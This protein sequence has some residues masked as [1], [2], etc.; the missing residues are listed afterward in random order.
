MTQ[1]PPAGF[2]G[3]TFGVRRT[4]D[5]LGFLALSTWTSIEA[6]SNATAGRP[7]QTLPSQPPGDNLEG[8]A[9]DLFEVPEGPPLPHGVDRGGAL[10]IVWARVAPHAE[11][12][13]HDMIRAV[14]PEVGA[15][16]VA[17]IQ[18]GRR[19]IGDHTELLVVASWR[20][21]LALHEF[22]Q[23][24]TRGTLDPAFLEL[25]TEWRFET[26]DCLPPGAMSVPA[27]G[28]AVLLADDGARYVD[29]SPGVETLLGVPA[30]LVLRQTL[31]DL[32]PP[33]DRAANPARWAQF[34][35]AGE[36]SGTFDILR[37]DG[38]LQ[39]VQFRALA[40]CPRPGIHA[41]VLTRPGDPADRRSV[42]EIVAATFPA[43]VEAAA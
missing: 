16:G 14:G 17:G 25:M 3:L 18:V 32:T 33:D 22:A 24:R 7:D 13:A 35:A 19:V 12:A 6:I 4:S 28:P 11:A 39:P 41:S 40:N 38:T 8:V 10:G 27:A 42:A 31:S 43:A 5:A 26:Y 15:A 36:A 21:R 9:I 2:A 29:A 30:E 37:P 23:R 1:T 34:L 20:D